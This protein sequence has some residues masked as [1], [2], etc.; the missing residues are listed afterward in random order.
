M[1]WSGSLTPWPLTLAPCFVNNDYVTAEIT[2]TTAHAHHEVYVTAGTTYSTA[3]VCHN[4]LTWSW[5]TSCS[6]P[7]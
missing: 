3:H 5:V 4:I 2:Y 1:A 6:M 7:V